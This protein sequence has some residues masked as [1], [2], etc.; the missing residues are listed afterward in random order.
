MATG[1]SRLASSSGV[2]ANGKQRRLLIRLLG[3]RLDESVK[4]VYFGKPP[5]IYE[6][7]V[8][9]TVLLAIPQL[10]ERIFLLVVGSSVCHETKHLDVWR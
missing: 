3:R 10:F 6:W 9:K 8:K 4:N 7:F 2:L 1:K 5:V